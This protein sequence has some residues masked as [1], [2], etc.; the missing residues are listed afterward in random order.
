[1]LFRSNVI[2]VAD[3][4]PYIEATKDVVAKYTVGLEDFYNAIMAK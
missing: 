2:E 4:T 1:M 3:K